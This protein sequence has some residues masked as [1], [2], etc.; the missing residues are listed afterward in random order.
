MD[1]APLHWLRMA[2][3]DNTR[4]MRWSLALQSFYFT[5]RYRVGKNSRNVDFLSCAEDTPDAGGRVMETTH[6][7]EG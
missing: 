5:V 3:L 2:K 4:L 7:G 1:H 6:L